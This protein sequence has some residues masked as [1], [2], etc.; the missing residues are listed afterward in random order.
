MVVRNLMHEI[1]IARR[2]K[3]ILE[4]LVPLGLFLSLG[5]SLRADYRT[6]LVLVQFSRANRVLMDFVYDVLKRSERGR[7]CVRAQNVW[8]DC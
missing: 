6:I 5:R 2:C 7:S 8:N 4:A 3:L 1:L